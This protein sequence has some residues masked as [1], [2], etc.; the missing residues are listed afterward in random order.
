MLVAL[1]GHFGIPAALFSP[2]DG[3]SGHSSPPKQKGTPEMC[4]PMSDQGA[5]RTVRWRFFVGHDMELDRKAV[6]G[7]FHLISPWST[8]SACALRRHCLTSDLGIAL[9]QDQSIIPDVGPYLTA[10]TA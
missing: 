9:F 3:S 6:L 7:Q 2:H 1:V 4:S 10:K 5:M 8:E